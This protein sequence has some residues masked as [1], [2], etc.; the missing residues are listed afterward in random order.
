MGR[1]RI[2][3][4]TRSTDAGRDRGTHSG[5]VKVRFGGKSSKIKIDKKDEGRGGYLI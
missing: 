2:E 5:L 4:K 3:M 1:G